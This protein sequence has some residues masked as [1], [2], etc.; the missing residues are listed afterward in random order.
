MKRNKIISLA[1]LVCL[2]SLGSCYDEKMEWGKP[3]GQGDVNVSDIPL[4]LKEKIANYDYI[5]A[6]AQKHTPHMLIGLGMGA[7]LYMED[8]QFKQVADDNFQL[9][10]TG[11]AMK[12]ASVVNTKGVLDFTTIDKFFAAIPADMPVYGHNFIWHTQQNAT[13]LNMLIA[14]TRIGNLIGNSDFEDGKTVW[15]TW[16]KGSA[17][18]STNGK[19]YGDKGYCMEITNSASGNDWDAQSAYTMALEVGKTYT[20]SAKVKSNVAAGHLQLI[21][22]NSSTYEQEGYKSLDN[23]GTTW[24][25]W[26]TTIKITKS[27]NRLVIN[28]GKVAATYSIDDISFK[29]YIEP[30]NLVSNSTFET[31]AITG[32]STWGKGSTAVSASGAGHG[33]TGYCLALTNTTAGNDWDTQSAYAIPFEKDQTYNISMYVKSSVTGGRLQIIAQHSS[34]YAQEGY[35][36]KDNIGT[37]WVK[38][39]TSIKITKDVDR[40]VLN[41][42]KVAGTYYIDDISVTAAEVDVEIE[43]TPAEKKQ[44]LLTD[45]ERWIKGMIDHCKSRVTMWDVLNEPITDNGLLRGVD[46]VPE[47]VG[48]QEFYWGQY[49]GKEYGLKAFQFAR[50]YGNPNDL[51]FI[52]EYGLE[53]NPGKLTA[54]IDYVKYIDTTNGSPIVDGIGTQMHVH[55]SSITRELVDAM[56]KTLAATGKVIRVTEL[57]VQVGTTTPSV[58]QLA[59]QA[60]VYQMIAESYKENIP[61]T[62][63]SGITIWS[64]TDAAK[65]HEYWLPDDAPNLFDAKYGR[66]HAYKSFCDGIAGYDVSTDF[67]GEDWEAGNK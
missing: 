20:F 56:F 29:E 43:K 38:W 66:K 7:E 16:G 50:Q 67:N 47:E 45:M 65:E 2:S 21:V 23:I 28:S 4:T 51:L 59:K 39:E 40:I 41:A 32:W 58:E 42:G 15:D 19:G 18:I 35:M 3:E 31:G 49:I 36:S 60:E 30:T 27:V 53:T 48:N 44:I 24:T 12:H 57:D 17:A 34:S 1:V 55:T 63:Q 8:A 52:N 14:P 46:I 33:G 26:T 25:T 61:E 10:T 9:F 6:Y 11:N 13:Y 22:Q 54:L 64:L 62:Q 5:K 37:E